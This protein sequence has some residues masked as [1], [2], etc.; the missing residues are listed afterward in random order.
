MPILKL[1]I[2]LENMIFINFKNERIKYEKSRKDLQNENSGS[3]RKL[4][5]EELDSF[6]SEEWRNTDKDS[7]SI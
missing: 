3:T 5:K 2:N 4:T 1:K 7:E 6:V